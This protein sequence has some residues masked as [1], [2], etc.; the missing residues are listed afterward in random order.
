MIQLPIEDAEVLLAAIKEFFGPDI[1]IPHEEV[2]S[3]IAAISVVGMKIKA[4]VDKKRDAERFAKESAVI[5][6]EQGQ[7]G[8]DDLEEFLDDTC[9]DLASHDG[10]DINNEG[11]ESQIAFIAEELGIEEARRQ[12]N[13]WFDGRVTV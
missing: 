8:L 2:G 9:H 11:T 6:A 4:L 7:E 13:E 12:M 10:S 3:K 1:F 5:I